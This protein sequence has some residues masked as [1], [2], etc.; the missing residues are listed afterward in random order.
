M[1]DR[2]KLMGSLAAVFFPFLLAFRGAFSG[3]MPRKDNTTIAV[4]IVAILLIIAGFVV[5]FL[6]LTSSP[7]TGISTVQT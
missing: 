4:L 1:D 6:F 7:G 5:I 3:S 2:S